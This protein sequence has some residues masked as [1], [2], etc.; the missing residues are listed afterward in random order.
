VDIGSGADSNI[1]VGRD[2]GVRSDALDVINDKRV[3]CS[4]KYR[5][6]IINGLR[7]AVYVW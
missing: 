6:A 1:V 4:M 5:E 2:G 3:V 7:T